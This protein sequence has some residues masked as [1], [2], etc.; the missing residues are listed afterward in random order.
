MNLIRVV[1]KRKYKFDV[2][3]HIKMEIKIFEWN[4]NYNVM[5]MW[6]VEVKEIR[7]NEILL[8]KWIFKFYNTENNNF[9]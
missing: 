1:V 9:K 3:H 4:C 5:D 2:F 6:K 7:V 8:L